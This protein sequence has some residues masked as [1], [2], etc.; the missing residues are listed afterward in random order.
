MKAV[1]KY[2]WFYFYISKNFFLVLVPN[3]AAVDDDAV[4]SEVST[5]IPSTISPTSVRADVVVDG[6]YSRHLRSVFYF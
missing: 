4:G 5:A 2:I 1:T 3:V 6:A